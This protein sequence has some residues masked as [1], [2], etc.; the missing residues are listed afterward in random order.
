MV[1]LTSLE[2]LLGLVGIWQATPNC[3]LALQY[4]VFKVLIAI[5]ILST[6][7]YSRKMR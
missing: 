5:I 7:Y 1:F 2:V 4:E 3:K 6:T